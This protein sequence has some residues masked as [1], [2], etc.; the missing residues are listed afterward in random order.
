M[1][2]IEKIEELTTEYVTAIQ[3]VNHGSATDEEYN[4]IMEIMDAMK[5]YTSRFLMFSNEEIEGT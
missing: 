3:A 4:N 2:V 5:F 1:N